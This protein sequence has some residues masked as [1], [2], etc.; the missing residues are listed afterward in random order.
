MKTQVLKM[1]A[2]RKETHR[3][4]VELERTWREASNQ[5]QSLNRPLITKRI[6]MEELTETVEEAAQIRRKIHALAQESFLAFQTLTNDKHPKHLDLAKQVEAEIETGVS[7]EKMER[8]LDQD[9]LIRDEFQR[10]KQ[11]TLNHLHRINS[12]AEA[13]K[14]QRCPLTKIQ[15]ILDH[16]LNLLIEFLNEAEALLKRGQKH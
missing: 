5:F 11:A 10:N 3:L 6:K 16:E 14:K 4:Q 7:S 1:V 13:L 15:Q 2:S 8:F 12:K 9:E